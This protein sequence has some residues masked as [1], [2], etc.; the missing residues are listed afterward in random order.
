MDQQ[1]LLTETLPRTL[2]CKCKSTNFP[3]IF[4]SVFR[5][6]STVD[7]QS[8]PLFFWL[9][10]H[11]CPE[12]DY[13]SSTFSC[14]SMKALGREQIT[15]IQQKQAK[16][17]LYSDKGKKHQKSINFLVPAVADGNDVHILKFYRTMPP[18]TN[19]LKQADCQGHMLQLIHLGAFS[20]F[21][22]TFLFLV[23]WGLFQ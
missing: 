23:K 17:F 15:S 5:K 4:G 22:C 1:I 16:L 14:H 7:K 8:S 13:I 18:S 10:A 19:V 12:P 21:I 3:A 11:Y 6:S 20:L 2:C 9:F